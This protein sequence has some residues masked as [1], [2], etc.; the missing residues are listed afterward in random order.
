MIKS[1]INGKMIEKLRVLID[2]AQH[3]VIT[4]HVSPDGDAVG[5]TMALCQV[6]RNM[7]KDAHVVMPDRLPRALSFLDA[8]H[9]VVPYSKYQARGS[10]LVRHADLVFCLDF[11]VLRRIDELGAVIEQSR[12]PRVLIDHHLDPEDCFDVKISHPEASSTC[13]L[14]YRVLMQMGCTGYIDTQAATFL[15]AGIT[16]DTGNLTYSSND[17]ELYEIVA[18]LLRHNIDKEGIYNK[19]MNTYSADA[20]RL[21]GY[22]LDQKMQLYPEKHAALIV[23]TQAELQHYNY[24]KGDTEGL[25]NKPLAIPEVMF[26]TF[27]REDKDK[28]KISCRSQGDDIDV[29]VICK[30]YYGGGGHKNAAGGDSHGTIDDVLDIYFKILETIK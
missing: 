9:D 20:L 17:P 8:Q 29:N 5:S 2:H 14:V 27:V 24:K 21:Q 6:L 7:G 23:L 16:T 4:C 28:I 13:E 30:T 22:A 15:F 11:N 10:Y 18:E 25:V 19:V 12:A 26:S 3:I 1:I